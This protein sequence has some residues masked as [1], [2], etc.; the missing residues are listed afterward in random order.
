MQ[1]YRLDVW[2]AG[3]KDWEGFGLFDSRELAND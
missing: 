1:K 3:N 2:M